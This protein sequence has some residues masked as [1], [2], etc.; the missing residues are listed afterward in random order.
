MLGALLCIG[1]ELID[2]VI[3]NENARFAGE[4]L[5]AYGLKLA[6][7][8]VVPDEISLI[9]KSLRRLLEEYDFLLVSGG[10]GPTDDDLT[11]EAAVLAFSLELEERKE[12]LSLLKEHPEYKNSQQIAK[13]MALLPKGSTLLSKDF[14]SAGFYIN[15]FQKP[16]FFLPGVPTQFKDLFLK[17]VI[18]KL[19]EGKF[20][21]ESKQ[22]L[23]FRFF[24]INE[25]DLNLFLKEELKEISSEVLIG[26]Y[27]EGP[28]VKIIFQ[29]P[30]ELTEKIKGKIK[31]RFFLELFA[32]DDHSLPEVVGRILREKKEKVAVAES[33]TGGL[34]AS[35]ITSIPGSSEYFEGGMVTYSEESKMKLLG[36][37]ERIIREYSVYSHE[38]AMAMAR[39][40]CQRFNVNLGLAT[41]GIA[42]PTGGLE[43]LPVGTVFISLA[44]KEKIFSIRFQLSGQRNWVQRLA[45]YLALDLLRRYLL[46]GKDLSRYRFAVEFKEEAF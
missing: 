11:V 16:V 38:T 36:V 35:L 12:I 14:S 45:S 32:E 1:H 26:Y 24:D 37:E 27:P 44:T 29:G 17:A 46:Y 8:V 31:D 6:E 34:L 3:L 30:L 23:V 33:C 18:P 22:V 13:K 25:T 7:V 19:L 5:K 4:T 21:N 20:F 42:G 10:L 9:V 15:V 39:G 43:D 40:A 2:G 41:T 28:E